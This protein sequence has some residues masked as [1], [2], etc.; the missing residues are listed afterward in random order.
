MSL[1]RNP[2]NSKPDS[3]SSCSPESWGGASQPVSLD[4]QNIPHL[5]PWVG[6][7][8]QVI[9]NLD[10]DLH[11]LR[12]AKGPV[13]HAPLRNIRTTCNLQVW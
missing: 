13:S 4:Y 11:G 9:G 7:L 10:G 6:V 5:A 2:S 3:R 12:V 1:L 8:H